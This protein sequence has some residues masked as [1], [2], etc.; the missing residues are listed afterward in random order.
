MPVKSPS[1]EKRNLCLS[2]GAISISS[3]LA[4]EAKQMNENEKKLQTVATPEEFKTPATAELKSKSIAVPSANSLDNTNSIGDHV[5]SKC[6][7]SIKLEDQEQNKQGPIKTDVG[8]PNVCANETS[9]THEQKP[10]ETNFP[11]PGSTASQPSKFLFHMVSPQLATLKSCSMAETKNGLRSPVISPLAARKHRAL[12]PGSPASTP[13]MPRKNYPLVYDASTG[14]ITSQ[15]ITIPA[16]PARLTAAINSSPPSSLSLSSSTSSTSSSPPPPPIPQR[17]PKIAS[18]SA[19]N[20]MLNGSPR[21]SATNMH[22][23]A[24]NQTQAVGYKALSGVPLQSVKRALTSNLK[25]SQINPARNLLPEIDLDKLMAQQKAL[26]EKSLAVTRDSKLDADFYDA[27]IEMMNKYLKSLPDYSEID[28]KL[29]QEFQECEDLYDRLKR[30]QPLSKSSSHQ[31]VATEKEAL[32]PSLKPQKISAIHVSSNSKKNSQLS[33]SSSINHM[34][35]NTTGDSLKQ[36]EASQQS[37]PRLVYPSLFTS[38]S[39]SYLPLLQRSVSSTQMPISLQQQQPQL[40]QSPYLP[41]PVHALAQ[42]S[43]SLC[44]LQENSNTSSS[45][46]SLNKQ[47]MNDFWN[48]NLSSSRKRQTPKRSV[49]NFDKICTP[50]V[51]TAGTPLKVDAQTAKKLAIYDPTVAEAAQREL[52]KPNKLQKNASLSH[53][54]IKV[55]QAVTKEDLYKLICNENSPTTPTLPKNPTI[56]N[57]AQLP[58]PQF[59]SRVPVKVSSYQLTP[60]QQSL[61]TL[62]TP[63]SLNKSVSL[64]HVPCSSAIPVATYCRSTPQPQAQP[65]AAVNS[66]IRSSSKTHIPCYMKHLP[67]LS[68]STSNSA[69]LIPKDIVAVP[70]MPRMNNSKTETKNTN[71]EGSS[72]ILTKNALSTTNLYCGLLKSASTSSVLGATPKYSP[73]LMKLP[74]ESPSA[75]ITAVATTGSVSTTSATFASVAMKRPLMSSSVKVSA[76]SDELLMQQ[77]QNKL[78][79]AEKNIAITSVRG[80]TENMTESPSLERKSEKSNSTIS[81]SSATATNCC[82]THLPH[83]SRFTSSFH[84]P[85][86]T[87]A[88]TTDSKTHQ[89]QQHNQMHVKHPLQSAA[90]IGDGYK[91]SKSQSAANLE[92]TKRQKDAENKIEKCINDMLKMSNNNMS[93]SNTTAA[94][95]TTSS[96]EVPLVTTVAKQQMTKAIQTPNTSTIATITTTTS[97]A[98]PAIATERIESNIL[99]KEESTPVMGQLLNGQT[100]SIATG[101]KVSDATVNTLANVASQSS[102]EKQQQQQHQLSKKCFPIGKSSS[103]SQIQIAYHRQAI[104]QRQQQ[105]QQQQLLQQQNFPQQK[106]P[107]LNWNTFACSAMS[108]STDP[109]MQTTQQSQQHQHPTVI[110]TNLAKKYLPQQHHQPKSEISL[111]ATI[112]KSPNKENNNFSMNTL[113]QQQYVSPYQQQAPSQQIQQQQHF[114]YQQLQPRPCGNTGLSHSA[115]FNATHRPFGFHM[116]QQHIGGG[117]YSNNNMPSKQQHIVAHPPM[118]HHQERKVLQTFDSYMYTKPSSDHNPPGNVQQQHIYK[119]QQQ[120]TQ[121]PNGI[122]S[123]VS[124]QSTIVGYSPQQHPQ[125]QQTMQSV[126]SATGSSA[127]MCFDKANLAINSNS[128][129]NMSMNQMS[130]ATHALHFIEVDFPIFTCCVPCCLIRCRIVA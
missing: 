38:S 99:A 105:Q 51:G 8:P 15:P 12:L 37:Q 57:T 48:E 9:S 125:Q 11:S 55:R 69:I 65:L 33:K 77:L 21:D 91:L 14:T 104:F 30:R 78:V 22:N 75:T 44:A 113:H 39:D 95:T 28:K 83:L 4:K 13:P 20:R 25:P 66:L 29:H 114:A 58:M 54:D 7:G 116:K 100:K 121:Q 5:E 73:F 53:L 129:Q 34:Y 76:L 103:T 70:D 101:N 63:G 115:S 107:F 84:I 26:D 49:W 97:V 82:T 43:S 71:L 106:R 18:N 36:P 32:P 90:T 128:N 102:L 10:Q 79:N 119:Q 122:S 93:Q 35:N 31:S 3:S 68:R 24:I 81:T 127:A 42:A 56:L 64:S 109:F 120:Q 16:V 67:S 6:F 74:A 96:T 61:P 46:L 110:G 123:N 87:T 111:A 62:S 85:S 124:M 41:S 98:A 60:A 23:S 17:A 1:R 45:N 86:S 126:V 2:A 59:S 108:G 118:A 117:L 130:K 92:F 89:S 94:T 112:Q 50:S 88:T 52:L 19:V 40:Q 80:D 47:L 27:E 72:K